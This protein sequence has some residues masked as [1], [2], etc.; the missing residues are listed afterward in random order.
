MATSTTFLLTFVKCE[1]ACLLF[2]SKTLFF[3]Y[4]T[5]LRPGFTTTRPC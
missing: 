4:L 3:I 1:S 5:N 2:E